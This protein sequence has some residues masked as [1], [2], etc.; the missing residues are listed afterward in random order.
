VEPEISLKD[1]KGIMVLIE[2]DASVRNALVLLLQS[3]GWIVNSLAGCDELAAA[4]GENDVAAVVSESSLP[5]CKP[6]EILEQCKKNGLPVIFTGHDMSLQG[7]V[8]LIRQGA[9]D[10]LDKPFPQR[11]LVNLLNRIV[12][13]SILTGNISSETDE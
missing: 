8:D 12:E 7:A 10:F 13:G 4:I 2:P 5:S 1:N 9:I 11:R 6:Q 3:E